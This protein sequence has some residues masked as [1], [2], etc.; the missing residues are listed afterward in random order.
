[1][2][3]CDS[4]TGTRCTRCTPPSYLRL[5]PDAVA[6]SLQRALD[7]DRDLRRPCS[8][9]GRTRWR[10]AARSLQPRRSAYR[11]Y[12]RSRS[13]AN[14]ADSSP[15]SPALIS[16]MTS[17]PS[18]G[19]RGTSTPAQPLAGGVGG[20]A[21]GRAARRR[22]SS[23]A[24]RARRRRRRRRLRATRGRRRRPG[25]ARRTGGR[26]CAPGR[27]RRARAGSASCRSML[28][29][30]GEQRLDGRE[31]RSLMA[32]LGVRRAAARHRPVLRAT[33]TAPVVRVAPP[34]RATAPGH[35]RSESLLGG[36]LLA[37]ARLEPGHAAT[38]VEDLLL[39]RVERVA[40]AADVGAD[41]AGR[42]RCCA[43]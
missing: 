26:A 2:R 13:P 31:R 39:A 15:P 8:R 1:M 4:V 40:G 11:R 38:G 25:R 22:T 18:S 16:R 28:G 20:L 37:V 36:G 29:V 27:R 33:T 41:L 7:L 35:R 9:R 43:S 19:S 3:P 32:V 14:S 21:R 24:R 34:W 6:G 12:M 42:L 30:L 5:R 17:R 10:R 23:S